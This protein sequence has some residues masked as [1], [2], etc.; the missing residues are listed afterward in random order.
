MKSFIRGILPVIF[1]SLFLS[2]MKAQDNRREW[3]VGYF[4]PYLSNIGGVAGCTFELK[5]LGRNSEIERKGRNRLQLLTQVGYFLQTNV[6]QNIFLNPEFVYKWNKPDKRFFL[7]ASVGT[8]YL[9]SFQ[10]QQGTLS[11]AT[12]ETEYTYEAINYVIPSLNVGLGVEP[13][14]LLGFYLKA[15]YG[16]KVNNQNANA[17]FAGISTGLILRFN[18]KN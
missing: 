5:E 17:A 11:L 14:K 16:R 10:R 8:G 6:S 15:T 18:S 12:G 9:V 3:Q 2:T 4:A 13:K 7:T 1:I